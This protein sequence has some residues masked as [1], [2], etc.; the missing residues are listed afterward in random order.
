MLTR[1]LPS[2][3]LAVRKNHSGLFQVSRR[4][5]MEPL[6]AWFGA[7]WLTVILYQ[8]FTFFPVFLAEL[9]KPAIVTHKVPL[10]HHLYERKNEMKMLRHMDGIVTQWDDNIDAS[11]YDDAIARVNVSM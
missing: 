9:H 7:H 4:T 8:W 11:A 10:L 6:T 2:S 1:K 3:A 5:V